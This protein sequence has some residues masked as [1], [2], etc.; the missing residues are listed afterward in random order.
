[1][2]KQKQAEAAIR[3][4]ASYGPTFGSAYDLYICHNCHTSNSS[5]SNLGNN[6]A[7]DTGLA[8]HELLTGVR[9]FTVEENEV[10]EF[11]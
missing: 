7:N 4:C 8:G 2:F 5:Y 6:Y 3:N 9:N 11:T 10:F 1:M